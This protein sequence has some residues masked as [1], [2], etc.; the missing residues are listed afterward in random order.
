VLLEAGR[1]AEAE[2]VYRR[3]LERFPENGWCLKGLER[4][5][6]AQGDSAEAASVRERFEEA[7]RRADVEL[8]GSRF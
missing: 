2:S 5:L 7:W 3:A 1:P 8:A 6:A 4:S